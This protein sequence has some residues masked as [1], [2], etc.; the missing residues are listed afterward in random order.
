MLLCRHKNLDR[1]QNSERNKDLLRVVLLRLKTH[2]CTHA[3]Q[4]FP[5]SFNL[6]KESAQNNK[7][8][9]FQKLREKLQ[10]RNLSVIKE[11]EVLIKFKHIKVE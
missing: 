3:P 1:M 6:P 9:V 4:S 7:F 5:K 11:N 8:I 10:K 2:P